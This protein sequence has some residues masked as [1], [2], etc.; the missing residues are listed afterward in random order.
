M[1]ALLLLG[2][3]ACAPA[4]TPLPTPSAQAPTLTPSPTPT[5]APSPTPTPPGCL[6][7]PGRLD[8][9][10][11]ETTKPPQQ[12]LIYLPP[13]YDQVQNLRYPVL[14]LLH[15]QTYTDDQWVRLGAVSAAD[16]LILSGEVPPFIIVFPDDRYWNLSAGP[17]FGARLLDSLLPYIDASYRTLADRD[18]RALGGL[19]RGGGWT[20]RLG[21][22]HPELFGALGLHSPAVFEDDGPL[23]SAWIKAIPAAS[24]PRLWLDVGDRDKDLGAVRQLERILSGLDVVHEFHLYSGDHTEAYWGRHVEEYLR[25]YASAWVQE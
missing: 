13:C 24:F 2:S 3:A 22:T 21:L 11:L 19:S 7:Q 12:Y 6:V 5:P 8:E 17:E 20:V 14:Y 10:V 9:G 1:A 15:G 23:L 18:H 25:W 4:P 16:Q